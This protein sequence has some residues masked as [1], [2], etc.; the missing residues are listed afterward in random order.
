[1]VDL[2]G[3]NQGVPY[4]YNAGLCTIADNVFQEGRLVGTVAPWGGAGGVGIEIVPVTNDTGQ[5]T[6]IL[7]N[8]FANNVLAAIDSGPA[9]NIAPNS[10]NNRVNNN[11]C[12]LWGQGKFFNQDAGTGNAT[13]TLSG[14]I[15][16]SNGNGFEDTSGL[17]MSTYGWLN[18]TYTLADYGTS[19]GIASSTFDKV[20]AEVIL[21]S[22]DNWRSA[23]TAPAVNDFFRTQFGMTLLGVDGGGG[24]GGAS[25]AG[26]SRPRIKMR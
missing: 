19:V 23:Y 15:V 5:D 17:A 13:T 12:A 11:R 14:N 7:R 22:K 25:A 20:M 3:F 1:M 21:Q 6:D 18:P 9:I 4:G 8:I 10:K 16:D 2:Y 26:V 24:G